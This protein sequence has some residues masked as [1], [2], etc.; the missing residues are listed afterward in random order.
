LPDGLFVFFCREAALRSTPL[1]SLD[2]GERIV[3]LMLAARRASR[4]RG[5]FFPTKFV[6]F[7]PLHTTHIS[8]L[9]QS[10]FINGV[11]PALTRTDSLRPASNYFSP[12]T[13]LVS[14]FITQGGAIAPCMVHQW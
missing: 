12:P 6:A 2:Y 8:Y 11:Y 13:W 10:R 9:S 5:H 1:Q 4:P 7:A 3:L 14:F